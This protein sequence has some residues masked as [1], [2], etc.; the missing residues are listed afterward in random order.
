MNAPTKTYLDL[1]LA[2][3]GSA[4]TQLGAAS[5]GLIA[6]PFTPGPAQTL[7]GLT[8]C[9]YQGYARQSL[10]SSTVTFTGADGL[11]YVELSTL[12]FQPTGSAS[13]NTAYGL[14]ITYGGSTT[15][16]AYS[17]SFPAP[18]PL[19]SP[20]SQITIT[21]RIGRSAAGNY[22]TNVISS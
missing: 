4:T 12:R 2:A 18:V 3:E 22:G 11:E 9:T 15:T 6:A 19:A 14:F 20:A 17:D 21:P 7:A 13:P 10:G 16:L 8:E 1:L 5:M